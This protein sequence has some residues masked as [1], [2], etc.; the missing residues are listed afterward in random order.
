VSSDFGVRKVLDAEERARQRVIEAERRATEMVEAARAE[1]RQL[2][3]RAL[4]GARAF[5]Q[6]EGE[7]AQRRIAALRETAE[8]ELE[9]IAVDVELPRIVPIA[10]RIA[11]DL[12]GLDER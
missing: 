2:E 3:A 5:R 11:R 9:R 4:D 8:R 6:T 12:I 1:A 10:E 7:E